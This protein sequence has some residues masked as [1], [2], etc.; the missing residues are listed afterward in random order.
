MGAFPILTLEPAATGFVCRFT[1]VNIA[2]AIFNMVPVFPMDRGRELRALLA[3]RIDYVRAIDVAASIG[4]GLALV[5]GLVGLLVNPWLISIA[6]FVW[7]GASAEATAVGL[8]GALAWVPV[9]RAMMT[10][11]PNRPGRQPAQGCDLAGADGCATGLPS[12]VGIT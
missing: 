8:R 3:E 6:L 4:Q 7:M 1:A 2:L 5:F 11:L 9:S 12:R 10:R